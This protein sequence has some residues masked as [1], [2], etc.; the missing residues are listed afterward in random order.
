M[1]VSSQPASWLVGQQLGN[2]RVEQLL[3]QGSVNAVYLA[4][5]Q[6][7]DRA[8]MLTAF[9]APD[10][11]S[12]QERRRFEERC[13]QQ[14][15]ILAQLHHP[16]ILPIYDFGL[17][18][19]CPYMV[20]PL[21]SSGSL[22]K[23]LKQQGKYAPEQIVGILKQVAAGL[24]YAHSQGVVHG[25]LKPANILLLDGGQTIQLAGFGLAHMLQKRGIMDEEQPWGHLLSISGTLLG[26]AEYL[27]PEVI[28]GAEASGSADI[29]ALG[30][31][32][33]ELLRGRP[34]FQSEDEWEVVRQ[35]I[36]QEMPSLLLE[37]PEIPPAVDL[38]LGKALAKDPGE[39]HKTAKSLVQAFE[40]VL[41]VIEEAKETTRELHPYRSAERET[42]QADEQPYKTLGQATI[43]PLATAHPQID[44][45]D[46]EAD[47]PEQYFDDPLEAGAPGEDGGQYYDEQYYNQEDMQQSASASSVLQEPISWEEVPATAGSSP[48]GEAQFAG[49]KTIDPFDWWSTVSLSA[50]ASSAQEPGT[51]QQ[52]AMAEPVIS[53]ES[54]AAPRKA[55]DK[56]RR[57]TVAWLAAGGVVAAGVLTVG[58][59]SLA[60]FMQ[61]SANSSGSLKTSQAMGTTGTKQKT[62]QDS[63]QKTVTSTSNAQPTQAATSTAQP[64]PT[65]Q[66]SPTAQPSPTPAHSG[67]VLGSTDQGINTAKSFSNPADGKGSLLIHLPNGS[68]VAYERACT[69]EGVA[70]NYNAGTHKLVCPAHNAIFDPGKGA[71]VVQG[72]AKRPLKM[73]PIQVNSDGTITAV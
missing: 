58:G 17:Q 52:S 53:E 15:G 30:V 4:H 67:V 68:F 62:T 39:R 43:P 57:R 32:I 65:V 72:P 2:Y 47:F 6:Q 14:L 36:E 8:V 54:G 21:V 60:R 25:T 42:P 64:S 37:C 1:Y 3:G 24:D 50:A 41:R 22:A 5:Q 59:I 63:V 44:W 66:P 61:P 73:V 9:L 48:Q 38:V 10:T 49:I 7:Q 12:V 13:W 20:T 31:V 29:Y 35:H 45:F 16:H 28:R 18:A 71:A 34:P 11:F 55:A 19:E 69:H 27:A 40:R 33:Y 51:F 70:V 46:D 23:E 56:G 26:S